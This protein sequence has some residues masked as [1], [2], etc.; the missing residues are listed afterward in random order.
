M[1]TLN[2]SNITDGTTSVGTGY[3]VNGSAKAFERHNLFHTIAQSM[4]V[5]SITDNGAGDTTV[6][7]SNA[8]AAAEQCLTAS[9]GDQDTSHRLL[10]TV[11]KEASAATKHRYQIVNSSFTASD[12]PVSCSLAHGDLA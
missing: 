8:F 2:V 9:G 10:S 3:V 6:T 7:Y 12:C 1:S 5:S 11:Q 4:N